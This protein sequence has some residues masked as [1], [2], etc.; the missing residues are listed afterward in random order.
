MLAISASRFAKLSAILRHVESHHAVKLLTKTQF[1]RSA[2]I[3]V[4][5]AK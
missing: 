5:V 1:P 2:S 4:S 3:V